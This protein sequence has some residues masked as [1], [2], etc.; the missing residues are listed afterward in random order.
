MSPDHFGLTS[1]DRASFFSLP[2]GK[3]DLPQLTSSGRRQGWEVP[4]VLHHRTACDGIKP[5]TLG[6]PFPKGMLTVP[7][8]LVL[9]DEQQRPIPLQTKVLTRWSCGS[10]QWLLLDFLARN[11]A[12][13]EQH[14]TLKEAPSNTP[15][16]AESDLR[17]IEN[18]TSVTVSTG[19]ATFR[20]SRTVFKPFDQ[21][22]VNGQS[23]LGVGETRLVLA[24]LQ[25]RLG[26]A[27]I[28]RIKLEECGA[29]RAT[30]RFEAVFGSS[31][32]AHLVGRLSFFART[33]LVQLRLTLHNPN[34]ARHAGGLWDL[35]DPGSMLFRH[36]TLDLNLQGNFAEH[37]NWITG[38]SGE[39][40]DGHADRWELYQESSGGDNW[41]ARTHVNKHGLVPLAFR[42][43]R[44]RHGNTEHFGHRASPVVSTRGAAGG[45]TVALP[46]FWQ[47]FPKA[48]A[49]DGQTIS[50]GFFPEQFGD[51]FEL[52]G[53]EQKTHTLWLDF[54]SDETPP[55]SR[56]HWVHEPTQAV[57]KA[58][59]YSES[60]AL[61]HLGGGLGGSQD[62]LDH[63]LDDVMRGKDSLIQRREVIDEFGWRNFGE[64]Y[65]DHEGEHYS[66]SQPIISHYNNQYDAVYGTLLHYLRTGDSFWWQVGDPMAR[67]VMDIDRYH[68]TKDKAAYNGGLFWFTDHYLSAETCTHRTYSRLNQPT[69]NKNYGG[70]PS[71]SHCFTSGLALYYLLTGNL[72]ALAAVVG[73]ADWVIAMD[74]GRQNI[75]GLLDGGPTGLASCTADLDY[76]GPGRGAGNSVNALLDAWHLTGRLEYLAKAESLIRRCIH[77]KDDIA[78]RQLWDVEKRWSYTVF[79]VA[80]DRYLR[81][82]AE[83][84]PLDAM[85]SYAQQSL[86]AY[87]TW[88]VVHEK[89]YFEQREQLEYPTEAWAGQELRKANVLRLAACH[90]EEPLRTSLVRRGQELAERAWNDL[91]SFESRT[92]ARAVA[93]VLVEG[94]VDRSLRNATNT[95]L[96]RPEGLFNHGVP[97]C[98]IPQRRRV[99]R[100]LK[101]LG[102]ISTALLRIV[103]P[104]NWLYVSWRL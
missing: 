74:D 39:R 6:L 19:A 94:M 60:G 44:L 75:L 98:F 90:A 22:I 3:V 26:T 40:G 88:M 73:L 27:R 62:R 96:P 68:T 32:R 81:L 101:T 13:G 64:L 58:E 4:L 7:E 10:V 45:V 97:E 46:E 2:V 54:A 84:G 12:T 67:H 72:D 36:L 9:I 17:V 15:A 35:G 56:L 50:V 41:R 11:L 52:Q 83:R 65:A 18:E 37:W 51:G 82:K 31:I 79:L 89:P 57:A 85:Y 71:S 5:T 29:V 87:A 99:F 1:A 48:L 55:G 70:G 34:R 30:L 16:N 43:Y 23:L 104:Y 100:Q 21:V 8:R 33:G 53:G 59:W 77:P 93:L 28:R 38:E 25:S 14:W 61:L 103:N 95:P 91:L 49:V 66:G 63:L 24:D 80:L 42:G 102:G 92:S 47:Q 86:L 76:H 78:A 69:G 20:L